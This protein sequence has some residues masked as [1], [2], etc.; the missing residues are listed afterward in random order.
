MLDLTNQEF[1]RLIA[2][3]PLDSK[4]NKKTKWRCICQCREIREVTAAY[5]KSGATKSCGCLRR[6]LAAKNKHGM[7]NTPTHNAWR[8]MIDRCRRKKATNYKYYGA[9]GIRVC[10]RWLKFSNFYADMGERPKGTTIER[11]DVNGN[12]EPGN[13]IWLDSKLQAQNTR[14]NIRISAHGRT[15]CAAEWARELGVPY[16]TFKQRCSDS[17]LDGQELID[18]F[19]TEEGRAKYRAR[20]KAIQAQKISAAACKKWLVTSPQGQESRVDNL[21]LFCRQRNLN[22]SVMLRVANGLY[23]HHKQWICKKDEVANE[24]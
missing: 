9:R 19:K 21:K 6:D 15:Q 14:R 11:K 22:Y 23:T 10:D 3:E 1:G 20:W 7:R 16:Q 2:L 18:S 5:L 8:G 17:G 12:Y 13:C 24:G 4:L